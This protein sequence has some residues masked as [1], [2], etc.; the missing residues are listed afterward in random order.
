M[1]LSVGMIVKNEEKYLRKCLEA[2][3]PILNSVPSELIIYDTGSSD[4]T[5]EIAK[6]FTDKVYS[7]EWHGD[8]A[9]ARNHT[10][11]KSVGEWYMF[12]DADEIFENTNEIISFFDSGDFRNYN[13]AS[14]LINNLSVDGAPSKIRI[15]RLLRLEKGTRFTEAIHE[16]IESKPPHK[17]LDCLA[18][19]YGYYYESHEEKV[20][21]FERNMAPNLLVYESESPKTPRTIMN[22]I[23]GYW[24]VKDTDKVKEFLKEGLEIVGQNQQDPHYHAFHTRWA[25]CLIHEKEYQQAV[26]YI[27]KYFSSLT[28]YN[29][30]AVILK[31][32]EAVSLYHLEKFK[33]AAEAM[34]EAH[35]FFR[36][37]RNGELS[38]MVG[39]VMSLSTRHLEDEAMYVESIVIY[40]LISQ[41]NQP[42]LKW[43]EYAKE[44]N[45]VTEQIARLVENVIAYPK[46]PPKQQMLDLVELI[47]QTQSTG[48]YAECQEATLFLCDTVEDMLGEDTQVVRMLLEHC[49]LLFQAHNGENVKKSLQEHIIK[50]ENIIK[51]E[52]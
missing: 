30:N 23:N 11:D 37:N 47:K 48:Q 19:H 3:S 16:Q 41:E 46:N 8:F 34:V 7:I 39:Q 9:W 49:E 4:D 17:F 2:L 27:R 21:K 22:I 29:Q 12:I 38:G 14:Y 50:V 15:T 43:Y 25:E 18:N 44:H 35:K 24:L 5:V 28:T 36:R 51:T 31:H 13:S 10:I 20:S 52:F 42:G 40:Y 33:E 6:D 32:S 1:L 45:F 26:E